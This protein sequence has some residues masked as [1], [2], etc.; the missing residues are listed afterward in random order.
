M[1][2][3]CQI[4]LPI[5]EQP[6]TYPPS[7]APAAAGP[8]GRA[9]GAGERARGAPGGHLRQPAER[10]QGG[11]SSCALASFRRASRIFIVQ[12]GS[13]G[14]AHP[15]ARPKL[16]L[17]GAQWVMP[18]GKPSDFQRGFPALHGTQQAPMH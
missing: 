10:G 7:P 14:T 16:P 1:S 11:R 12:W 13:S 9:A 3:P 8:A 4:T 5:P 18:G 2:I 17:G 15:H 6:H